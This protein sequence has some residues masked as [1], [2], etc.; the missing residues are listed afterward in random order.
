RLFGI[1]NRNANLES[2]DAI[3]SRIT[4]STEYELLKDVDY[5]I[6]NVTEKWEIK[7]AVHQR[8]DAICPPHCVVAVNTSA[9]SITRV[10]GLTRRAPK[11]IGVHFMNPVPLKPMVEV[12][13]GYHTS[14]ETIQITKD[15]LASMDKVC[16]VVND[17]PGFV[18][19]RVMMLT[20]NEAAFLVQECV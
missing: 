20:V 13:R 11:I 16:I 8:I 5:V 12:I 1:F 10:A 4:F 6:E 14:E 17:S 3:L 18:T 7:Q 19:N 15:L 9:I 2:P